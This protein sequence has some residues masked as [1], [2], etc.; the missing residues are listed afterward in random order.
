MLCKKKKPIEAKKKKNGVKS[1]KR[2]KGRDQTQSYF[3]NPY[4]DRKKQ[5]ATWQHTNATKNFDYTTISDRLRT[6]SWV[7]IA[8]QLVCL[9][10]FT[11]SQTFPLTEKA[12]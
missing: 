2:E 5:K 12:V 6:V 8:I 7:T 11:G 1:H 4:T 9:N 10:W 3:K